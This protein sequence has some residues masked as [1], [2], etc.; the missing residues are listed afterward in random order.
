MLEW[1]KMEL[2]MKSQKLKV[3]PTTS[4]RARSQKYN[5]KFK[6]IYPLIIFTFAFLV[7]S[8]SN[9]LIFNLRGAAAQ[10]MSSENFVLQGGNFNMTSG[11]KESQNFKLSDVVG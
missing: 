10:V 2:D 7:L 9:G 4:L 1:L 8:L 11:N 6:I 3:N 5:S